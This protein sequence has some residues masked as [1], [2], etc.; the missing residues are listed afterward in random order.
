MVAGVHSPG[1]HLVQV[2]VGALVQPRTPRPAHARGQRRLPCLLPSGAAAAQRR[3]RAPGAGAAQLGPAAHSE[4]GGRGLEGAGRR[5]GGRSAA[6][7]RAPV[8]ARAGPG[9][10]RRRGGCDSPARKAACP[11]TS[12]VWVRGSRGRVGGT[13]S[14]SLPNQFLPGSRVRHPCRPRPLTM[15]R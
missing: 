3:R 11:H 12:G 13:R 9:E 8:T 1:Q 2:H 15:R 4:P 6:L 5:A 7:V 14:P 10:A